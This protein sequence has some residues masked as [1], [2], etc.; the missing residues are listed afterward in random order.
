[1]PFA[2]ARAAKRI[3]CNASQQGVGIGEDSHESVHI[4]WTR[5][6]TNNLLGRQR[7]PGRKQNTADRLILMGDWR[8]SFAAMN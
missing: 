8:D 4:H 2:V 3:A 5:S 7:P 6:G 1:M